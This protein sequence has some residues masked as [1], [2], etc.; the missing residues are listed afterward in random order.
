MA[1]TFVAAIDHCTT[2]TCWHS[3][4]HQ[5]R[6]RGADDGRTARVSLTS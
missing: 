4:A 2:S 1:A 6:P 3:Q 5:L